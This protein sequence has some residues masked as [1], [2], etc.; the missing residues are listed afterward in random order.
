[1]DENQN[2]NDNSEI[3]EP[4]ETETTLTVDDYNQVKAELEAEKAKNAKLYARVKKSSD[5]KPSVETQQNSELT[6]ELTKLKLK[7]DHGI[8]DPDAI[9][10][11]MKNGGEKA[12]DNPY[13]K[14]TIDTML[15]Q[16]KAE[17]A[18]ISDETGKSEIER[19]YST[20]QLKGM[21]SEELEKLLPHA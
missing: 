19:K 8:T 3:I 2:E 4:T 7:V 9:E 20:N 1:M 17:A 10:F 16:K 5:L 15:Q 18:V 12:L 21:S 6:T 13:I 14:G 11:V